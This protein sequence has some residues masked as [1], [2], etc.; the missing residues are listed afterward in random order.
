M[1]RMKVTDASINLNQVL[2]WAS[3]LLYRDKMSKSTPVKD[4]D[5][6][7]STIDKHSSYYG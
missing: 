1:I 7:G 3:K 5:L 2:F 6:D 4:L